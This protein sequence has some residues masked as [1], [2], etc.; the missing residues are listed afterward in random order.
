MTRYKL[1]L[2]VLREWGLPAC[3]KLQKRAGNWPKF[4]R[5]LHVRRLS[6]FHADSILSALYP[7]SARAPVIRFDRLHTC[8]SPHHAVRGSHWRRLY[9]PKIGRL[10][11]ILILPMKILK[12]QD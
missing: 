8:V 12:T 11:K 1:K 4:P 10:G 5:D 7:L 2:C 9:W 6:R 3:S